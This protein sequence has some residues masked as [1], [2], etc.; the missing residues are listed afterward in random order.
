MQPHRKPKTYGKKAAAPFAGSV[1]VFD[2]PSPKKDCGAASY[3]ASMRSPPSVPK[4]PVLSATNL[5]GLNSKAGADGSPTRSSM[6]AR[7]QGS[8]DAEF[9]LAN[10][11]ADLEVTEDAKRKET[12]ADQDL[13]S[14]LKERHANNSP[15]QHQ[16]LVTSRAE[17]VTPP[18]AST[19]LSPKLRGLEA[20]TEP[21]LSL[22]GVGHAASTAPA[23]E[24]VNDAPRRTLRSGKL[25]QT[26]EEKVA[27]DERNLKTLAQFAKPLLDLCLLPKDRFLPTAFQAWAND[28]ERDFKVEKI[29]E[30][31]FGEVY[32]LSLKDH[33]SGAYSSGLSESVLK[34]I[35][36]K[37]PK[38]VTYNKL[39][40]GQMTPIEDVV[41]EVQ[42]LMR[43]TEIP[44][45]INFREV[46][47]LYGRVPT[48]FV[49]AWKRYA[50]R[51]IERSYFP[52]PGRKTSYPDDQ[53]WALIE[54][55]NAG[56]DLERVDLPSAVQVWDVFWGVTFALA[57]GEHLA[58]FEHRDL[59]LG[60]ICVQDLNGNDFKL[61]SEVSGSDS[62]VKFGLS[63][64]KTT[65]IDYTL[66][67]ASLV[68]PAG[69]D[70]VSYIDLN[71]D[72]DLFTGDGVY[73]YEIYRLMRNVM[74]E[75][76]K[77]AKAT[78]DDNNA[79]PSSGWRRF[80]PVTNVLWLDH[81]LV[82][83][84]GRLATVDE[85]EENPKSEEKTSKTKITADD[86]GELERSIRTKLGQLEPL[87]DPDDGKHFKSAGELVLWAIEAGWLDEQDAMGDIS[88]QVEEIF[89]TD[90]AATENVDEE[91][92]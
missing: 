45:F 54:M 41:T 14:A 83:L 35:P 81:L 56:S 27:A 59:H 61:P 37:P 20:A 16:Q 32:R 79:L 9:T 15:G 86:F 66:S 82:M 69:Q 57:K 47:V 50:Q 17:T 6:K 72:P 46:R 67:R 12:D 55:E 58:D 71:N 7:K 80:E 43:M 63:G 2:D 73:Q 5:S 31:S 33:S 92:K 74:N 91:T 36:M 84:I 89:Q 78:D 21:A 64:L 44:G 13:S 49:S 10:A 75:H 76:D 23:I 29:A 87:L 40:S 51:Q 39:R 22:D 65:I 11:F 26:E 38:G 3:Y 90:S 1:S 48:Q 34:L 68:G 4:A 88:T 28:F 18:I 70:T 62:G 60:N 25:V 53:L 85:S 42:T 8:L 30:A 24:L 19:P 52:N 77:S